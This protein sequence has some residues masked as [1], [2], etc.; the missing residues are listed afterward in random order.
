MSD[1]AIRVVWFGML[2]LH[3]LGHF[4]ALAAL[5]WLAARPGSATGTW[6]AARSWLLPSLAPR[7]ATI[8]ASA[9]WIAS[10]V[11][12]VAAALLFWFGGG[13]TW[14]PI[15]T[16]SAIVSTFGIGLFFGTWPLFNT[17]AALGVNAVVL[18]ALLVFHWTP[19]PA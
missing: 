15:A 14:Q 9:F 16:V 6:T 1:Q 17:V 19:P 4:G 10:L 13:E 2:V 11:G 8:L 3:G 7:T 5:A 18:V 12:F